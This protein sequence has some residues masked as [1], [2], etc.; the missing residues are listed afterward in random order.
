V[1]S[2]PEVTY[3]MSQ[4]VR[5][6]SGSAVLRTFA[7]GIN[8]GFA[9]ANLPRDIM[10]TWF[11]ARRFENG[12]W[13]P[14]YNPNLPIY[15]LQM[16]RDLAAVFGDAATGGP[17]T[18]AYMKE[19][20]G[21]EFL[22]HQGRLFRR[23]R[24]VEGPLDDM[25]NVLGYFG[26]TSELAVRLA[27]R[28]RM[29]RKGFSPKEATFV[30]RDYMDFG[31][32]GSVT[33]AVDNGMAYLNASVQGTRG[34]VRSFKPGSGSALSS[35][36]KLAQFAALTAGIYIA[37]SKMCS[38]TSENL[39]GNIDM[40]NNLCIPLG[41][42]FGFMDEKGEMR[43]PYFKIPLDPGQKFF[44]TFFEA[45]ADKWLGNEIDVNRV[46][47]SL[48]E[49]SPVGVTEMPPTLSGALGYMTNKDFWL[50]EDIW[51]QTDKPFGWPQSKEEYIPGRT[52]QAMIDIGKL[53]GLSPDRLKYAI[54]ELVTSGTLWSYL[55]GQGY[56]ELLGDLP[57][58]K[59]QQH[60]AMALSKIPVVKRFF[61][62]TNPYSKHASKVEKIEE[63]VTIKRFT[64]NRGVDVLVEGYLY[65]K[66][67]ERKEIFDY[68]GKFKDRD[69]YNRLIDRF[70]FEEAIKTLPE[71]S[72]WKRMKGLPVEAK[73]KLFVG[74]LESSTPEE[75]K[76]LWD[77]YSIVS[78]AKGVLGKSFRE[79]VA[80]IRTYGSTPRILE[81]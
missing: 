16:G 42:S 75:K 33:K 61:G 69:T 59:K 40:Q 71:K 13:K 31:Q 62:V 5:Y 53:T 29:I 45:C 8:W 27:I 81:D 10:H 7:T 68:A 78:R 23:G 54:E 77:Q 64:E 1:N 12:K 70:K 46:V 80:R 25:Y 34:L 49:L 66:N 44:K 48:K 57:E 50:N 11:T 63:E 38:K 18:K 20:G 22:T 19:G 65:D 30:A 17:K 32:G 47:D 39:K 74:E 26:K 73:A 36:Y 79:E 24:H 15:G 58:S 52:P 60:L 9:L 35:T 21:M 4:I 76:E 41:D 43:Y 55:L 37:M 3:K 2:S 6:A 72:F 67:V 28:E 56:E 14:V 51:R